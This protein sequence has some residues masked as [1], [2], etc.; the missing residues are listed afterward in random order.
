MSCEAAPGTTGGL[1][2]SNGPIFFLLH[3]DHT[4]R[5]A[6]LRLDRA[7]YASQPR[8][9]QHQVSGY[10]KAAR[11]APVEGEIY[12]LIVPDS[13]LLS[14]ARVAAEVYK[15]LEGRRYDTVV[16]IAPS[17]TGSFP[18][19]HICSV[20]QYYTPLGTLLVDDRLR[21][22]LCD[23]DDDI[24]LDDSG[25]FHTEGIDVQLPY[26][27]TM[28]D[29]F[30]IVPVV[31]GDESPAFCYELGRAIGEITYN[32][33]T[34]VVASAEALG[35][36]EA[37]LAEFKA[38]FETADI[39]RLMRLLHSDRVRMTGKGPLLVAMIAAL[40]RRADKARVLSLEPTRADTPGYVGAV[41][42]R[43]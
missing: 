14:G 4:R 18:R 8:P 43:E 17:H 39:A 26:L 33:R 21:H 37:H 5:M 15:L 23:E 19:I 34:L 10:L 20:D 2:R 7:I 11:P 22:E 42:W 24:F 28:L 1:K 16:L 41:L 3:Q 31:M 38:C 40:H 29:A 12:A 32:Q 6:L 9:L 35:A 25:H 27:Q 30:S 13:N 36:S